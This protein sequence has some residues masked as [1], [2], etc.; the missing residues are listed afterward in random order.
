MNCTSYSR[1]DSQLGVNCGNTVNLLQI[2]KFQCNNAC[3]YKPIFWFHSSRGTSYT[4]CGI[5][6]YLQRPVGR[7]SGIKYL[8]YKQFSR[9]SNLVFRGSP[10]LDTLEGIRSARETQRIYSRQLLY[11][12]LS[13]MNGSLGKISNINCKSS[14]HSC[15]PQSF[16]SLGLS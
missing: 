9:F 6:R 8:H 2:Y 16:Y 15:Q 13:H 14:N 4:N 7:G 1:S 12:D 5:F 11:A 3:L 10:L